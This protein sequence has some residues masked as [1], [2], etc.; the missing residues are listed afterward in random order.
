[1]K[2]ALTCLQASNKVHAKQELLRFALAVRCKVVDKERADQSLLQDIDLQENNQQLLIWAGCLPEKGEITPKMRGV[3]E[4]NRMLRAQELEALRPKF[5]LTEKD[6]EK[7]E[8]L[9]EKDKEEEEKQKVFAEASGFYA[10]T[11]RP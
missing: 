5:E 4:T 11:N 3:A 2:W 9:A 7:E 10:G 6:K 1:M 8:K